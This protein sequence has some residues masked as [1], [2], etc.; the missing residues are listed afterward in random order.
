MRPQEQV[1]VS[2]AGTAACRG[3][4][5]PGRE[6][7]RG[8]VTGQPPVSLALAGHPL[9]LAG[10]RGAGSIHSVPRRSLQFYTRQCS[11]VPLTHSRFHTAP[12]LPAAPNSLSP[13]NTK[14]RIQG[15][16]RRQ[17]LSLCSL[18]PSW[19]FAL[20]EQEPAARGNP[21]APDVVF[22]RAR[23]RR[24]L[25]RSWSCVDFVLIVGLFKCCA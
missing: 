9:A 18:V 15:T 23:S 19:L 3:D 8:L 14:G 16:L 21:S 4:V 20:P 7:Q 24:G 12:A 10:R 5:L 2:G 25:R 22:T 11:L 1:L 13:R 17:R 6:L